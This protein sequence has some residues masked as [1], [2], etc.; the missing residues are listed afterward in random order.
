MWVWLP[1]LEG[2]ILKVTERMDYLALHN[3]ALNSLLKGEDVLHFL[4]I[5]SRDDTTSQQFTARSHPSELPT[6]KA[7][8]SGAA[9]DTAISE[10][11]AISCKL[12]DPSK[13]EIRDIGTVYLDKRAVYGQLVF[14]EIYSM[15]PELVNKSCAFYSFHIKNNK[16]SIKLLEDLP[17]T[18]EQVKN[19]C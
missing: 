13:K 19:V 11:A 9:S 5:G 16:F 10:T 8:I 6:S 17:K 15:L 12:L 4:I 1:L 18:I 14:G 2:I 7:S 3:L